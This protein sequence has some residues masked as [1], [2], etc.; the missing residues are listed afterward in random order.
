MKKKRIIPGFKVT[1]GISLVYLILMVVMPL[2]GL[3]VKTSSLHWDQF[4]SVISSARVIAACQLSISMALYAAAVSA[5]FGTLLA[6]VLV[7]YRFPGRALLDALIDLPVALP[8][9]VAGLA[10]SAVYASSGLIGRVTQVWGWSIAFTTR[11]IFIALIF[12][13]LPFIVRTVQS[14]LMELEDSLEEAAQT[15]GASSWQS[16]RFILFPQLVPAILSGVALAFGR[17]VGEYGSVIFI[18]GNVPME[19]EIAPLLIVSKLEQYDYAG[20]TAIA[21]VLLILSIFVL[22]IINYLQA[23]LQVASNRV[24]A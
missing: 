24:L 20:A 3:F 18:A 4:C 17:A 7:R 16:F 10:L 8:T 22:S 13:G 19:S 2:G 21:I 9:A 14:V 6:W 11:G 15:L 23:H 5:V 1:L 12:V